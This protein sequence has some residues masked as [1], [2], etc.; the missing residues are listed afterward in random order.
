VHLRILEERVDA[1]AAAT[2]EHSARLR[3]VTRKC[4]SNGGLSTL[5]VGC[6]DPQ[7]VAGRQGNRDESC[8]DQIA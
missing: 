4:R 8:F 7:L 6:L 5:T 2:L 1:L 3:V